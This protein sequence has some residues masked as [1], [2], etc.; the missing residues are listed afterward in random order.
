M[1]FICRLSLALTAPLLLASP[2]G[3]QAAEALR[4]DC[5]LM[6]ADIGAPVSDMTA[7]PDHGWQTDGEDARLI[8]SWY[9][10]PAAKAA[11]GQALSGED[12][13]D[14]GVLTAQLVVYGAPLTRDAAAMINAASDLPAGL[15][16]DAAWLFSLKNPDLTA[17]LGAIPPEIMFEDLGVSVA[18][19]NSFA[20]DSGTGS[21]LTTGWSVEAAARILAAAAQGR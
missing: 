16:P 3:L 17:I 2:G 5:S 14:V 8:C 1:S 10:P 11:G 15:A 12:Y 4:Y 9:S 18:Y 6:A 7:A 20:T 13:K 21:R 19:G